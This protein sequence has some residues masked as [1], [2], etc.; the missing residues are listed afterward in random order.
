M[1]QSPTSQQQVFDR[2]K[3][4]S[5]LKDFMHDTLTR[6]HPPSAW[7][8]WIVTAR[9]EVAKKPN[10]LRERIYLIVVDAVRKCLKFRQKVWQPVSALWKQDIA[11][12][13]LNKRSVHSDLLAGLGIAALY[14]LAANAHRVVRPKLF[15]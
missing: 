4:D 8:P 7:V 11:G 15:K 13:D 3:W 2:L 5:N 6:Y 9:L 12:G 10:C 14:K 1:G